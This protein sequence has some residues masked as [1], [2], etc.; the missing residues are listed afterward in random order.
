VLDFH[1]FSSDQLLDYYRAEASAIRPL[2]DR[3]ITT[4]FMV[5]AHIENLDYWSWAGDM[6]VIANDHYLDQRLEDPTTEL[7][8]AADA[9]RGL[10]GGAGW[11]LMEHSTGAV[12]W[13]PL[14]SPKAPGEMLRNSLTHVARG[15]DAVCFFQWRASVQGSEKFHSAMLPHAGTDSALWR[16]VVELG[17]IVDALAEVAGSRVEADAALVYSWES[18]WATENESRPSQSLGYLTQVHAAY[19]ALR[20][21]GIT[22][23]VVAPGADL[24]AYKMV[25]VPGLHLVTETDAAVITDWIDA[26]GTAL[27]TFYSGTVDE[28]DRVRTGGYAGPFSDAVGVRVEEFAPVAPGTALTLSDGSSATLWSERSTVTTAEVV[29]SFTDGPSVSHPAITRNSWGAGSAWY[30]STLLGAE[31]FAGVV[32]RAATEAGVH[33]AAVVNGT[34]SDVEI[35]RRRG[36]NTSHLFVINHAETEITVEVTGF[37]MLTGMSVADTLTVPGGAVRIIRE[38]AAA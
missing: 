7:A 33:P 4:N 13:Q 31:A 11:L 34:L 19:A 36:E 6:D 1:R 14:N 24:S 18:W 9:T 16:D 21:N 26:G 17:R 38:E 2:S 37:E 15:A 22:V 12:N 28:N 10:A 27:I 32:A 20:A 35:V 29:A 30:V 3:P 8:F 23:D 25:V 5:T